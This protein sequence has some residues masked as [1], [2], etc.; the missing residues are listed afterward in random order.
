MSQIMSCLEQ[1]S[2]PSWQVILTSTLGPFQR[3]GP[4]VL[5]RA[6]NPHPPNSAGDFLSR[7]FC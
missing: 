2:V 7:P 6:I 4:E 5:G 3:K 1:Q